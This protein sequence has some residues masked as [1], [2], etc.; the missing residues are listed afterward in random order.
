VR[1]KRSEEK[2]VNR[3][4]R[5]SERFFHTIGLVVDK[6]EVKKRSLA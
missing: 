4:E 1:E 3:Q 2:K 6:I 5:Q